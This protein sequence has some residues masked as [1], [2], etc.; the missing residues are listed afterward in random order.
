MKLGVVSERGIMEVSAEDYK[1]FC[2]CCDEFKELFGLKDWNVHYGMTDTENI[3]QTVCNV[4]GHVASIFLCNE[5]DD[6]VVVL[7]KS[8]L[9]SS[10]FHEICHVVLA[11]L[12]DCGKARF[13]T[14][15]ELSESEEAVIRRMENAYLGEK[16]T[17]D[18]VE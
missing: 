3:A 11:R 8:Q 16:P 4:R 2:Q 7:D 10:A 14:E 15:Y 17:G 12:A 13:T 9:R 6:T 5:W 1:Y 18:S